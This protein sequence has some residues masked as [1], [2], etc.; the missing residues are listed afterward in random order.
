MD[1]VQY[2]KQLLCRQC[3]KEIKTQIIKCMPCEKLFHPSCHK[4]HRV[5]NTANELI[6]CPGKW[7]IYNIKTGETRLKERK[8]SNTEENQETNIKTGE[9]SLVKGRKTS[10]MEEEQESSMDY[11]IDWLVKKVRDEMV[12]KNEIKNIITRIVRDELE[13]FR[14]EIEEMRKIPGSRLTSF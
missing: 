5:Y 1:V 12:G 8:I 3:R 10:N 11:K 7:E 6:V 4:L 14:K 9:T 2:E 13:G